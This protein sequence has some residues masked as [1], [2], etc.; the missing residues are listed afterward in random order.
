M[1]LFDEK[2]KGKKE[3]E[4]KE[5]DDFMDLFGSTNE[6]NESAQK[7]RSTSNDDFD[8]D[9]FFGTSEPEPK[10]EE[11]KIDIFVNDNI[12]IEYAFLLF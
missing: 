4:H 7:D 12:H 5:S 1:D 8:M 6:G 2:P 10:R 9:D 3:P 11:V